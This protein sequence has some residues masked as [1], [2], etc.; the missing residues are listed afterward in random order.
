MTIKPARGLGLFC[1]CA[2]AGLLTFVSERAL[3]GTQNTC[4]SYSI[5]GST[6][7]PVSVSDGA[8]PNMVGTLAQ[9]SGNN[10]GAAIG[11][12]ANV[13]NIPTA[14]FQVRT[15]LTVDQSNPNGPK[16]STP[17]ACGNGGGE[18]AWPYIP[19]A[20][21]NPAM[22]SNPLTVDANGQVSGAFDTTGLGGQTIG[23]RANHDAEGDASATRYG[24]S[25][26]PC[27]DL[28][29]SASETVSPCD[30]FPDA[31]VVPVVTQASGD[32]TPPI[33]TGTWTFRIT[34]F[35]CKTVLLQSAQGG[36][37]GWTQVSLPSGLSV[38]PAPTVPC[39]NIKTQGNSSTVVLFC[40]WGS[41]L[42]KKYTGGLSLMAGQKVTIDVTEGGTIPSTAPTGQ[43]RCLNG[44]WSAIYSADGGT[45]FVKSPYTNRAAVTVANPDL[46]GPDNPGVLGCT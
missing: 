6:T 14:G 42:G 9:K 19:A 35:A 37:S 3:A 39:A 29:I 43:V 2:L 33:G 44:P 17:V 23:F 15:S 41:Q 38:S 32:G 31:G 40:L 28:Q 24:A 21:F 27:I 22:P 11:P 46:D 36:S 34:I 16:I 4:T 26:S 7:S 12:D 8:T 18:I 13:P 10:C 45:T 20:G 30:V 25:S 5:N 1:A